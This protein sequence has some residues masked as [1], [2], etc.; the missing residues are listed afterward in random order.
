MHGQVVWPGGACKQGSCAPDIA[1]PGA[2]HDAW[3]TQRPCVTE[4]WKPWTGADD[5]SKCS[6]ACGKLV[7]WRD[8]VVAWSNRRCTCACALHFLHL[9]AR[10]PMFQT[11]TSHRPERTSMLWTSQ[12]Q[13]TGVDGQRLTMRCFGESHAMYPSSE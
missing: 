11:A 6:T 4:S 9:L 12:A 13:C 8:A 7:W 2:G 5:A 10:R 1:W 3:L